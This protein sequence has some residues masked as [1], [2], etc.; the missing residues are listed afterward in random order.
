MIKATVDRC[1]ALP[2]EAREEARALLTRICNETRADALMPGFFAT[3]LPPLLE[4]GGGEDL[5]LLEVVN[6]LRD[7]QDHPKGGKDREQ[8]DATF[9]SNI[10]ASIKALD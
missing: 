10:S 5:I 6:F 3:E 4:L 7:R 2:S 1:P 8:F 9:T